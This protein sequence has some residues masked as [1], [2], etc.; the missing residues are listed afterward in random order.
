MAGCAMGNGESYHCNSA[1]RIRSEYALICLPTGSS[2][3]DAT[4][5]VQ[6]V[7]R[8]RSWGWESVDN[9]SGLIILPP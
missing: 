4:A 7:C 6:A 3:I 2:T 9:G 8:P 5:P 1:R